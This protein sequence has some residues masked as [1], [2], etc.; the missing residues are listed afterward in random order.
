[1]IRG[2]ATQG[3]HEAAEWV[4]SFVLSYSSMATN[5]QFHKVNATIKVSITFQFPFSKKRPKIGK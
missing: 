1:M 2:L 4:S 3:R 5:F